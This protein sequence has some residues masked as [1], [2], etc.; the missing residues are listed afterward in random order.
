MAKLNLDRVKGHYVE[1]IVADKEYEN[2]SFIGKGKLVDG[3]D[4]L[5]EAKAPDKDNHFLVSTPELDETKNTASIDFVNAKGSVLRAHQLEVGD[6]VTVEQKLHTEGLTE[7]KVLDIVD[8]K[9]TEA[10]D[11]AYN[12]E[13]V[14]TIGADRRPAYRVRK[15]K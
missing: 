1:S 13:R 7:G 5:Y 6:T 3:E 4:R 9:L 12:L 2:G 11:G 15:I 10:A 14:T 8:G